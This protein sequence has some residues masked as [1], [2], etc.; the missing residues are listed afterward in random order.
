M[1]KYKALRAEKAKKWATIFGGSFLCAFFA[2]ITGKLGQAFYQNTD[3]GAASTLL[4]STIL[5]GLGTVST[6]YV[7][8]EGVSRINKNINRIQ[9]GLIEQEVNTEEDEHTL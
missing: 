2:Y 8:Y 7:F 5:A 4:Y 3:P 1:K 9:Q 6:G